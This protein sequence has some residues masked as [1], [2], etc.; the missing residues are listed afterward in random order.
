MALAFPT[1][2][3]PT[4]ALMVAPV[5]AAAAPTPATAAAAPAIPEF[6]EAL[7]LAALPPGPLEL[8]FATLTPALASCVFQIESLSAADFGEPGIDAD[9]WAKPCV[10]FWKFSLTS[11]SEV[12]IRV[13][14]DFTEVLPAR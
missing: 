8:P 3:F 10:T 7:A 1:P 12:D 14:P 4:P 6:A 11:P 5:T 9:P 13:A 2:A